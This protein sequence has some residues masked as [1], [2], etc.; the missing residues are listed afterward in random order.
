MIGMQHILYL[1]KNYPGRFSF[2]IWKDKGF[3]FLF[4]GSALSVEGMLK[5]QLYS[6]YPQIEIKRAKASSP[7]MN[8]GE[9]IS[10]C[11]IFLSGPDLNLR[12]S[13]EFHY[14]PLRHVIEAMNFG[15]GKMI[16]QVL[17]ERVNKIPKNKMAI[18]A[19]KYGDDFFPGFNVPI[20]KCL[21]RISSAS[22]SRYKA[23][24]SMEHVARTFSVFDS[25]RAKLIPKLFQFPILRNS[26]RTLTSMVHRSFPIFHDGFL[27]SIPELASMVHLPFGISCLDY[28]RTTLSEPE[29]LR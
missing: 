28:T 13:E 5:S 24:E 12:C 2:E 20:F 23:R 7:E 1:L 16:V 21:I 14:D 19:Q 29:F 10:S 26:T 17:F 6:V 8:E 18:I 27:I 15:K 11:S 4:F 3:R 25:K 22:S 9:Y